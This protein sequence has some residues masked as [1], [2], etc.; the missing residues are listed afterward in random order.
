MADQKRNNGK[1]RIEHGGVA[2][3]GRGDARVEFKGFVNANP[4]D[5]DKSLFRGW[6]EDG[7]NFHAGFVEACSRGF[8][9]STSYE[10]TGDYYRTTASIWDARD[11]NAGIVLSLRAGDPVQS[12]MRCVWWLSWKVA[13]VLDAPTVKGYDGESW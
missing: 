1:G 4:S 10:P 12:L 9:F 3:R 11:P 13:Y 8:K 5:A 7:D 6:C 2:A